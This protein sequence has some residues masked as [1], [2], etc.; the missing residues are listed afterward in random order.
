MEYIT[1][2]EMM[3]DEARAAAAGIGVERLMEKAG[4]EVA[5]E[6]ERRYGPVFRKRIVVLAGNGNNGGDGFVAARYL[7]ARGS[8]VEVILLSSPDGIRTRE[9]KTNWRRLAEAEVE[10]LIAEDTE[11]LAHLMDRIESAEILIDAIFGTGIKGEVREPQATAI[12]LFNQSNAKKVALDIPSGLDPLTGEAKGTTVKADVT[13]TLH[14]AKV[15]LIRGKE[16][17]GEIVVVPIGIP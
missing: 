2:E 1:P 16:Y 5:R 17:A 3:K 15:G 11:S 6:V 14:K 8:R 12:N 7:A 10:T 9:A 4:A 13:I